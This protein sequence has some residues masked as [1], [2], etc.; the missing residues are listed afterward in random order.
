MPVVLSVGILGL[1]K[2]SF[3]FLG[4]ADIGSDPATGVPVGTSVGTRASQPARLRRARACRASLKSRHTPSAGRRL[5]LKNVLGMQ[6][7]DSRSKSFS[8]RTAGKWAALDFRAFFVFRQQAVPSHY[9]CAPT[10]K[11]K[12]FPS[13]QKARRFSAD[14]PPPPPPVVDAANS[15]RRILTSTIRQKRRPNIRL[16]L[17]SPAYYCCIISRLRR[18]IF[19]ADVIGRQFELDGEPS[20]FRRP[21]LT[22]WPVHELPEP[23]DIY[24]TSS[25]LRAAAFSAAP[26]VRPGVMRIRTTF[27]TLTACE[28]TA[29]S[30]GT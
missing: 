14:P 25:A 19:L 15:T 24:S 8:T 4:L 1:G 9:C 22:R 3:Q 7:V 30:I 6:V 17:I 11:K 28:G 26:S 29:D 27:S 23:G 13:C 12:K 20:I 2:R 5:T 18:W 16:R 10:K 21:A